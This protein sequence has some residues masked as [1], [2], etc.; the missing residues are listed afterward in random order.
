MGLLGQL[1]QGEP[2][3]DTFLAAVQL[4][5]QGCKS[6]FELSELPGLLTAL[7]Q[8]SFPEHHHVRLCGHVGDT[9]C[10]T[11]RRC[12]VCMDC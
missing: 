8:A 7:T 3:G 11:V 10:V 12:H 9:N 2:Q 6:M 4:I 1:S 5:A